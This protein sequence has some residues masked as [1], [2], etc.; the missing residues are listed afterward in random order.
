[1]KNGDLDKLGPLFEKYKLPLY[2]YFHFRMGVGEECEDMVQN[3][4]IRILK[5]RDRFEPVG[6]FRSWMY[7]IAHNLGVDHIR[8]SSRWKKKSDLQDSDM[9]EE[10]TTEDM[11]IGREEKS[12]LKKAMNMLRDDYREVLVLSRYDDLRYREIG[13]ITGCTEGAVKVRIHRALQELRRLYK[14]LEK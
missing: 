6:E 5:Y 13:E 4:F 12:R 8:K 7:S 9:V 2:R 14:D 3:V 10:S 11:M 1:M